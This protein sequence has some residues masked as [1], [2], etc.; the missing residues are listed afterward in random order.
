MLKRTLSFL[1]CLVM[2]MSFNTIA[3]AA[4]SEPETMP[5][6]QPCY[7]LIDHTSSWIRGEENGEVSCF[8][9]A[10]GIEGLA[11]KTGI[12]VYLQKK[13]LL[14][15]SNTDY[16]WHTLAPGDY[17]EIKAY[18]YKLPSKGTYRV[19]SVITVY[20]GS[21]KETTT[22]YSPQYTYGG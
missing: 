9:Y 8:S 1:M 20:S 21:Q 6:I 7:T 12:D 13:V 10:W 18:Y 17:A 4:E 2:F 3:F 11:T 15:W 22:T 16:E 5:E 14:W 19:K